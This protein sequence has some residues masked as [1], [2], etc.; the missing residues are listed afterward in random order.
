MFLAL[1]HNFWRTVKMNDDQ[2]G[3]LDPRLLFSLSLDTK[4]S[5]QNKS[6]SLKIRGWKASFEAKFKPTQNYNGSKLFT[7]VECLHNVYVPRS[8]EELESNERYLCGLGQN[9]MGETR[10]V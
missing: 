4:Y 5:H 3:F 7:D 9:Q 1:D 2:T 8:A 10:N 6:T